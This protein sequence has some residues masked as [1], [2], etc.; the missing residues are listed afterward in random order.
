MIDNS[1]RYFTIT[2]DRYEGQCMEGVIYHAGKTPGIKY[3][4]FLELVLQMNRIFDKM[5]CPKQ[6][7]EFRRF[8]GIGYPSPPVREYP[9]LREGKIATFR[10]YVKYRYNATWQGSLIWLEGE[11]IENFESLLQMI[12]LADGILEG[13]TRSEES[14]RI[15]STCQIAVNSNERG[16]IAGSVQNAFI[17][18][19]EDFKGTIGLADAM[20]HLFEV[21]IG[22]GDS[23]MIPGEGKIISE[24]TWNAYRKGG[25]KA[26]FVVKIL[27]REHSTWQGRICWRESGESRA[28]RSFLEMIIL[29]A[30]ALQIG[31]G[32]I[33]CDD[34]YPAA[35]QV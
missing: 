30:S 6:T 22:E 32:E 16:L 21:G 23:E 1:Y 24:E 14:G 17:N 25:K 35:Q 34:R 13:Q 27:Y 9:K 5:S 20:V 29:M 7:V 12:R 8:S 4:G 19:M 18:H 2:V 11:R 26:T 28:F 10:I 3:D 33:E 15:A 31:D